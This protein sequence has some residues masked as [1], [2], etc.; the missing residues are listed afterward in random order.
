M[1]IGKIIKIKIAVVTLFLFTTINAQ[2]LEHVPT[3]F[4]G[5]PNY[6]RESNLD[7]N[8]IRTTVFNSGYSGDPGPGNLPNYIEYEWPKNTNRIYIA[9][10]GIMPGG[11]VLDNSEQIINITEIPVYRTDL[12]GSSWNLE[13]VPGFLNP[14]QDE[15]A[16]SD[17]ENSWPTGAQGGWRDK[18]DDFLD[19]GWVGSWNGFFGKNIFNADQ[20][21]YFVTSDDLY[22]KFNYTPDTNRCLASRS[23][24]IDGRKS[25]CLVTG[26]NK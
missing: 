26:F 12:T 17:N 16:R 3:D 5:D 14:L 6:R 4:R 20:E 15:I 18:R 10:I 11:E 25:S 13:P 8:N 1:T 21:F 9:L 23:W 2:V 22:D 7:G 24:I 19:P